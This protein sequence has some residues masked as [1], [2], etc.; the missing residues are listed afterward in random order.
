MVSYWISVIM[1]PIAIFLVAFVVDTNNHAN[2]AYPAQYQ[3][4]A[5]L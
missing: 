3:V 1:I 2:A 5:G 4:D